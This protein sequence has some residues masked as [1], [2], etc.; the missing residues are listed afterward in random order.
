MITLTKEDIS[1]LSAA[2]RA[3]LMAT[4]FPKPQA[5]VGQ[6][7][8]GFDA[9]DFEDVVDLTP[10]QIEEFMKGCA[11]E[12]IAGLRVIAEHGPAIHASK[13][14][15]A[16]IENFSHFQSRVTKRTRTVTGQ[17]GVYLF[18][19]DDWSEAPDGVGQYAVTPTT[20]RSLRVYFNLV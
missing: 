4:I 19:W 16:G 2:T 10:G 7:P 6:M 17:K 3:E 14:E 5:N 8:P 11:N 9:D 13:L 1:K 12:T 18:A 15:D 20:H